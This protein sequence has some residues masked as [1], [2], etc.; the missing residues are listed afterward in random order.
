MR[1]LPGEAAPDLRSIDKETWWDVA[2]KIN[3]KMTRAEFEADYAEMQ[4][5]KRKM[6]RMD[7]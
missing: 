3:P 6:M 2:R 7:G 4:A 5:Y 1:Q